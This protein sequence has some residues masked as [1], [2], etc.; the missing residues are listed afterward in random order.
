MIVR[1][2]Y[3]Q[4]SFLLFSNLL[5]IFFSDYGNRRKH[6]VTTRR[7]KKKKK[8]GENNKIPQLNNFLLWKTKSINVRK[9]Q[10]NVCSV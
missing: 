7:E 5:F 9:H 8:I 10:I 3:K 6:E 1:R 2:I 4:K